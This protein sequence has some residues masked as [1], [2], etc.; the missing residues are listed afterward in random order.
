M[1]VANAGHCAHYVHSVLQATGDFAPAKNWPRTPDDNRSRNSTHLRDR[2]HVVPQH[3]T[4]LAGVPNKNGK[5]TTHAAASDADKQSNL[6]TY[7]TCTPAQLA[8]N[9][10]ARSLLLGRP[11]LSQLLS[12]DPARVF[13][14]DNGV[15]ANPYVYNPEIA[16]HV[17][18][19]AFVRN[20]NL[21]AKAMAKA[22][23]RRLQGTIADHAAASSTNTQAG[24]TFDVTMAKDE[25]DG[26]SA[27]A[28][29]QLM[30]ILSAIEDTLG[31]LTL[32]RFTDGAFSPCK[33][34][35][36]AADAVGFGVVRCSV[37]ICIVLKQHLHNLHIVLSAT[38]NTK[39]ITAEPN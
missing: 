23:R 2:K 30:W 19:L 9:D 4:Y 36:G 32:I 1:P 29:K 33:Y 17:I 26:I 16:R 28:D 39:A 22:T 5:L 10:A 7:D 25:H 38:H 3:Q 21:E 35:V 15:H 24:E 8:A 6:R 20:P 37:H 11:P 27:A 12:N 31:T 13:A 34:R 14:A 18:A